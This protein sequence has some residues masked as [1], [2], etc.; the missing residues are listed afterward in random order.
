MLPS[1]GHHTTSVEY[2]PVF[3]ID[4]SRVIK[5]FYYLLYNHRTLTDGSLINVVP[6]S[7]CDCE[8]KTNKRTLGQ[9]FVNSGLV[10]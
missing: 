8:S 6:L 2:D 4:K 1:T 7:V 3:F 9:Q 10:T 5:K